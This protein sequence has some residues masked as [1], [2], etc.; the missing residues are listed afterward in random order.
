MGENER[1]AVLDNRS[2]VTKR[3]KVSNSSKNKVDL[4][5]NRYLRVKFILVRDNDY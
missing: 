3:S 5:K 4:D 1:L 2:Q